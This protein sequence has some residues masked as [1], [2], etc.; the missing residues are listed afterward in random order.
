MTSLN[1]VDESMAQVDARISVPFSTD[2]TN[3]DEMIQMNALMD[4]D[5]TGVIFMR[6]HRIYVDRGRERSRCLHC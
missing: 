2:R 3:G 4:Y 5:R 1:I 6:Q